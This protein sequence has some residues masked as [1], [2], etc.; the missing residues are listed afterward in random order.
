[1]ESGKI[2]SSES[3]GRCRDAS[4]HQ[5]VPGGED[6]FVATRPDTSSARVIENSTCPSEYGIECL[7]IDT[8]SCCR[9]A[10]VRRNE[11]NVVALEVAGGRD[12]VIGLERTGIG[13]EQ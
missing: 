11:E 1:C 7:V 4:Q 5:A 8:G 6:F 13:A 2:I 3:S 10:A 9:G 12:S